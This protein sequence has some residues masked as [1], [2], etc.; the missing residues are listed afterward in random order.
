M[1]R[2]YKR[3]F[4]GERLSLGRA[5]LWIVMSTLLI[6]GSTTLGILYI[7]HIKALRTQDDTYR[8]IAI[9][10]SSPEKETLQTVYLTELLNLSVDRPMN[11]Y[12]FDA[13]EAV[14][15]LLASPLIKQA[16][17]KK[18]KPGM[19]F[20]DYT[21][22]KPIA[23]L[24]DYQNAAV[25][26]EGVVFPFKPFFTPKTLPEIYLGLNQ[27][28]LEEP[29]EEIT[30]GST[31]TDKRFELALTLY[32]YLIEEGYGATAV[33]HQIDVSKA[34]EPSYGKRQIVLVMEDQLEKEFNGQSYFF[35]F[36]RLIRLNPENYV[37]GLIQCRTL[38]NY[39]QEQELSASFDANTQFVKA[40]PKVIDLRIPQ[41]AYIRD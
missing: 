33:I 18:I 24:G 27:L 31:I 16:A 5:I 13:K 4:S 21:M 2:I 29:F 40:K 34:H 9:I 10:Q 17:V 15:K 22:R 1:K 7:Q 11:L 19:L 26:I 12:R 28:S 41:L 30:W 35:S 23:Y 6:S 3:L 25:D 20:I 36:P 38:L 39:L 32:R 37:Q 8:V 14:Q